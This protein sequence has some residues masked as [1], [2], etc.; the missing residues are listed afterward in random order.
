MVL[1]SSCIHPKSGNKQRID[2][3]A[4]YIESKIYLFIYPLILVYI[5]YFIL[6]VLG[7]R[8]YSVR[9]LKQFLAIL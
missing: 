7:E 9:V 4:Y 8:N 2:S 3:S 1:A 5:L 6:E